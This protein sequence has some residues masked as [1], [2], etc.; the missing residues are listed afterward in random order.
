MQFLF[1][2]V[3]T[4][5]ARR[6]LLEP[7]DLSSTNCYQ[8][9]CAYKTS[10]WTADQCMVTY[11]TTTFDLRACP[12]G[13]YCNV[14][15]TGAIGFNY[16][17]ADIV[18]NNNANNGEACLHD[19]ECIYG[20]CVSG[21]CH[22]TKL[23]QACRNSNTCDPGLHCVN[24]V[25]KELLPVGATNCV[26]DFDC[27]NSACV[28]YDTS[29]AHGTCVPY[30]TQS[31]GQ[32]TTDCDEYNLRSTKCESGTCSRAGQ[33]TVCIPAFSLNHS[34]E[35]SCRGDY[36]CSAYNSNNDIIEETC[37][38]GRNPYGFS[39]CRNVMGDPSGQKYIESFRKF[40]AFGGMEKCNTRARFDV[41]CWM[42]SVNETWGMEF[43]QAYLNFEFHPLFLNNDNCVK[44]T[45][46]QNYWHL[47]ASWIAVA[48]GVFFL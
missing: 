5:F 33:A 21:I 9:Q 46:T 19:I 41:D 31:A 38:C 14:F 10:N 20:S 48:V 7:V 4:A 32:N 8:Y 34:P 42:V 29:G 13:Q 26:D 1:L 24:S 30:F 25:C 27:L 23:N 6:G 12:S 2:I 28:N 45:L 47:S 15:Q 36:D 11:N 22:G 17:C 39:Y 35:V 43:I 16:T 40:I 44:D 37:T 18:I 3:A